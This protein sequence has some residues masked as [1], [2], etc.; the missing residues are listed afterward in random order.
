[1][2]QAAACGVCGRN[3]GLGSQ[4]RSP[5]VGPIFERTDATGGKRSTARFVLMKHDT[6]SLKNT[7]D[8]NVR[9]ILDGLKRRWRMVNVAGK[10]AFVS[11]VNCKS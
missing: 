11:A 10:K 6:I 2:V 5:E 9:R 4:T 7:K 3:R 8:L 1:M